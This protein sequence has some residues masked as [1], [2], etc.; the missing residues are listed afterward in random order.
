MFTSGL[1]ALTAAPLSV[2]CINMPGMR[3]WFQRRKL[4]KAI[5]NTRQGANKAEAGLNRACFAIFFFGHR[6][7][8][9]SRFTTGAQLFGRTGVT[10]F[11]PAGAIAA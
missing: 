7:L 10:D 8:I 4:S 1:L 2:P 5:V 9:P 11:R 6:R 3:L